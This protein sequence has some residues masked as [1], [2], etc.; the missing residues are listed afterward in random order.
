MMSIRIEC[1]FVFSDS[2]FHYVCASFEG[3]PVVEWFVQLEPEL[4]PSTALM[5]F[6]ERRPSML[7]L[8]MPDSMNLSF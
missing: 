5:K 7:A 8:S 1:V 6:K 2:L 3:L 4:N